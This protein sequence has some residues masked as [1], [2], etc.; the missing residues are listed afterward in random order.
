[1]DDH[2]TQLK[3]I[4]RRTVLNYIRKHTHATKAGLASATGFTF[5]AVKKILDEL[6]NQG[7]VRFACLDHF[8]VQRDVVAVFRLDHGDIALVAAVIGQRAK[9]TGPLGQGIAGRGVGVGAG[10]EVKGHRV[11]TLLAAAQP[12]KGDAAAVEVEDLDHPGEDFLLGA[13]LGRS[14]FQSGGEVTVRFHRNIGVQAVQQVNNHLGQSFAAAA[15][16]QH[17]DGQQG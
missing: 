9:D 11:V 1:M 15:A 13:A 12:S 17:G 6:E 8:H 16:C 2:H 5:A 10:L 4:N 14:L 7:L 3:N